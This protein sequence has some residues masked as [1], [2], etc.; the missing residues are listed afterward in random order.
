M[1]FTIHDP[2]INLVPYRGVISDLTIRISEL[3]QDVAKFSEAGLDTNSD[4]L[5]EFIKQANDMVGQLDLYKRS[6]WKE[7]DQIESI[8]E[9]AASTQYKDIVTKIT[10]TLQEADKSLSAISRTLLGLV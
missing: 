5:I 9:E 8:P 4:D 3:Q 10:L 6:C 2:I 7:F 1:A